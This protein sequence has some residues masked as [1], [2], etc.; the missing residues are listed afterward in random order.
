MKTVLLILTL[1]L[2]AVPVASRAQ[3]EK[4]EKIDSTLL[5]YY[6]WCN[7]HRTDPVMPLKADTLF[8][9]AG[10]Q[11]NARMQS[12]ALCL[13]TDYYYYTD[14][15]DSLK[16]WVANTQQFTR[17]HDQLTHYYFVWARLILYYTKYGKYTLAL[18]ELGR[19]QTQALR[20]DYKPAIAEAYKQMGHIY[21]TQASYDL[22]LENY[23]KGI[24]FIEENDVK[25]ADLSYLY[26]QLAETYTFLGQFD[27]AGEALDK[28]EKCLQ[29]PWHIWRI[30]LTRADLYAR[31]GALGDA[32]RLLR[33]IREKGGDYIPQEK[34]EEV[35][36]II[37]TESGDYRQALQ[38]VNRQLLLY[39]KEPSDGETHYIYTP[40]LQARAQIHARMGNFRNAADDLSLYVALWRQKVEGESREMLSEFATLLDVERL[41]R[42]K[43]EALQQAQSERLRRNK[44]LIIALCVILVLAVAFIAVQIRTNRRLARAKRAAEESDRMKGIF[45]RHITHEINTPL[46]SIVG[47]SELAAATP[48]PGEEERQAYL[49]I[50]RENS[51]F[52]QKLIDDVLYISDIESTDTPP[53]LTE[54]DIDACCRACLDASDTWSDHDRLRYEPGALPLSIRTSRQYVTKILNELLR[55]A[56]RHA[57]EGI[58]TLSYATDTGGGVRFT[59]T[60]TGKG[61]PAA[62]A[63]R[64]FERFVKLDP[65]SQGMG[66]GLNVCRLIART[67]GGEVRLDTTHTSGARFVFTIPAA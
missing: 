33:E 66:L 2:S 60:D 53:T 63:E 25:E 59:V 55:N 31:Q 23:R 13:R 11:G 46:N 24:A 28:G 48:P 20:D 41:D 45:I 35:E 37:Y 47:F 6:N 43:A 21:R 67:L 26:L 62:E 7:R 29:H 36:R 10:E 40:L 3:T 34:I 27:Q 18:Y 1:L 22:A 17:A 12:V 54:V 61:I 39:E 19:Y 42:E 8:R 58:V 52:L 32:R 57:P 64:I 65:F 49:E 16:I 50:I 30:T 5:G 56:M 44:V 51:G 9:L 38:L 14:N 15:L 4:T